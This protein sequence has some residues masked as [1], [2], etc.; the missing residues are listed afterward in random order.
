MAMRQFMHSPAFLQGPFL[1]I[2]R[3][4]WA[5]P[6]EQWVD[7][8]PRLEDIEL[9]EREAAGNSN[10]DTRNLRSEMISK[11]KEGLVQLRVRE[12]PGRTRVV[13]LVK[14]E[15]WSEIPWT[16]WSRIFQAIGHPVSYVLVYA[17]P[18]TR[19]FPRPGNEITAN[20]VNAGYSFICRTDFIVLY[21][22]EEMT[23]VLLHELLHTACFDHR[24]AVEDLEATT[25]A[26]TELLLCA[27]L[28]KGRPGIFK[29]IW[30]KQC[31]WIQGQVN[32]LMNSWNVRNRVDYAW[33][34]TIGKY[35]VLRDMGFISKPK[36]SANVTLRFTTPE[37]DPLL[38]S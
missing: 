21:R 37:W 20:H 10:I 4:V 7:D 34:Y 29:T 18:Q 27:L 14:D 26:W 38:K 16:F 15:Q 35:E 5:T 11:W 32:V 22:F 6:E 24:K 33:R 2:A 8:S 1:D 30:K 3:A 28:S 13:A 31:E 36:P 9:L 19:E 12:L 23:R 25:E 17:H